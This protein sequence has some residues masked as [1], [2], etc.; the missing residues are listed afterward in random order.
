M[1]VFDL[2]PEQRF[3]SAADDTDESKILFIIVASI[4]QSDT[5]WCRE[6]Q[7]LT[8]NKHAAHDRA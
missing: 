8:R 7:Q 2:I 5:M 3:I 1:L 6:G 4:A